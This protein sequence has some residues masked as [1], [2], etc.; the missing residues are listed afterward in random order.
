[1]QV[2][3]EKL[4][5]VCMCSPQT[6]TLYEQR[7]Y[8]CH[9]LP[10]GPVHTCERAKT[11]TTPCCTAA[12]AVAAK[13]VAAACLFFVA[14][15]ELAVAVAVTMA[16]VLLAALATAKDVVT[17]GAQQRQVRHFFVNHMINF[18]N[19]QMVRTASSGSLQQACRK[20]TALDRAVAT[21]CHHPSERPWHPSIK[22][23]FLPAEA[24]LFVAFL[25]CAAWNAD[26][27][28]FPQATGFWTAAK[29]ATSATAEA[30][31]VAAW[32]RAAPA[33]AVAVALAL[34]VLRRVVAASAAASVRIAVRVSASAGTSA[35]SGTAAAEEY[36]R[37]NTTVC[38]E[39]KQHGTCIRSVFSKGLFADACLKGTLQ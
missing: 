34:A 5:M 21:A 1:M 26:E 35:A 38:L 15:R 33:A 39:K 30:L 11:S 8:G 6:A 20:L 10:H 18:A 32:F 9:A 19:S 4:T 36:S 7:S 16:S 31:A 23:T 13:V 22:P 25:P 12:V 29:T 24:M 28:T 3:K 2:A 37:E 14:T 17:A 27:S